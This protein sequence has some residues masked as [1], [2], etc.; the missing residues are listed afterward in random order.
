MVNVFLATRPQHWYAR[1]KLLKQADRAPHNSDLCKY[2]LDAEKWARE[3]AAAEAARNRAK[4][5]GRLSAIVHTPG[6]AK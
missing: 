2:S 1:T 6:D 3:V 4:R 5:G